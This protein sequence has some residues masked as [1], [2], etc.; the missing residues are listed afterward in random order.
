MSFD[1]IKPIIPALFVAGL[2]AVVRIVLLSILASLRLIEK[3]ELSKKKI[4]FEKSY[5]KYVGK[6]P[7]L[8]L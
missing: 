3:L 8:R 1:K 5:R 4:I 7:I 2:I 6:M